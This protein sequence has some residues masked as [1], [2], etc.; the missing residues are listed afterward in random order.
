[1]RRAEVMS[2]R[3]LFKTLYSKTTELREYVQYNKMKIKNIYLYN[4][5]SYACILIGSHL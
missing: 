4:K 3:L 5:L 1:M 2:Y